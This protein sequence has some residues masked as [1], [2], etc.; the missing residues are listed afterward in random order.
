MAPPPGTTDLFFMA[1]LTIMMASCK[2]RSASSMNCSEPPLSTMVAV[3]ALG[4]PLNR[5]YLSAPTCACPWE[6]FNS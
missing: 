6:R 5:L 2:L 3:R 4:Q 1:R